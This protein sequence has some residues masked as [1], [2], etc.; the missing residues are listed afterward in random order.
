MRPPVK[1]EWK[2]IHHSYLGAWFVAFGAFFLYMNQNN[3]LDFLNIIYDIFIVSGIYL[4]I[5]DM[6]EHLITADTPLRCFWEK[7]L[8][9]KK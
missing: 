1:F 3:G 4:I 6:I 5:D 2:G 8:E 9:L 7:L